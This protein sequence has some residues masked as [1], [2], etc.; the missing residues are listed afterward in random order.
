MS[1]L[2]TGRYCCFESNIYLDK[3]KCN[4]KQGLSH[5]LVLKLSLLHLYPLFF[6]SSSLTLCN[7]ILSG[8]FPCER[9]WAQVNSYI[10]RKAAGKRRKKKWRSQ[11][12]DMLFSS[13][14][15]IPGKLTHL[16][17]YLLYDHLIAPVQIA[18]GVICDECHYT[19]QICSGTCQ[20]T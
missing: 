8:A 20:I 16:L 17:L 10:S 18:F 6:P 14:P 13:G 2:R 9:R 7:Y 5:A 11:L 12:Q 3:I 19:N 1:S 4:P 15:D